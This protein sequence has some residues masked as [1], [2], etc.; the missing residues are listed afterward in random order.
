M[1]SWC[2]HAAAR[3]DALAP[4]TA[5]CACG[6]RQYALGKDLELGFHVDSS[7]VTLNV[8]LGRQFEGGGLFFRGV[9][10]AAHQ[11]GPARPEEEV[12]YAHTPGI[13]ILHRGKHRHGAHRITRG[14]RHNLILW[15]RGDP[16]CSSEGLRTPESCQDYCWARRGIPTRPSADET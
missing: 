12:S 7:D 6:P 8:C 13:A 10:C 16:A 2:R 4:A 5:D 1:L 15:C 14:E 11:Q 9:R 3:P